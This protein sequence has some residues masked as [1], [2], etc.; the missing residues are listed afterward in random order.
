VDTLL[1]LAAAPREG[2]RSGRLYLDR[3]ERPFDRLP[4]TRLSRADRRALWDAVTELTGE[5]Q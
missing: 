4:S 5:T 3:R 1:W 2:I